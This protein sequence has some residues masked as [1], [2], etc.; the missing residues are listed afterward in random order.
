MPGPIHNAKAELS[1][2]LAGRHA[3]RCGSNPARSK[4]T[5][6]RGHDTR[7]S[8]SLSPSSHLLRL[9]ITH[10][11]YLILPKQSIN[12]KLTLTTSSRPAAVQHL[13]NN[14]L[15]KLVSYLI[16]VRFF[17]QYPIV[18]DHHVCRYRTAHKSRL[19]CRW[20]IIISTQGERSPKSKL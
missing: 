12:T 7:P 3:S 6:E 20:S 2:W 19:C 13:H 18:S 15:I 4:L 11:W 14:S 10:F 8:Q 9:F 1:P 17:R 5:E 16:A